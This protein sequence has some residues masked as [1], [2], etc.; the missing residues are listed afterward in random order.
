MSMQITALLSI[1]KDQPNRALI[2]FDLCL[3]NQA[4]ITLGIKII[5]PN[6]LTDLPSSSRGSWSLE[7]CQ[8]PGT[9][10]TVT[11]LFSPKG[12][13]IEKYIVESAKDPPASG[14]IFCESI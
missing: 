4:D 14:V 6:N 7:C 13:P 3:Q 5:N 1:L 10:I 11:K 9:I 8:P 12:D 2:I